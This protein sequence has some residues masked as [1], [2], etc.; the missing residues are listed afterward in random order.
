MAEDSVILRIAGAAG[1]VKAA[2]AGVELRKGD[3]GHLHR[4]WLDMQAAID[5][6]DALTVESGNV[7]TRAARAW[8]DLYFE[9]QMRGA[10]RRDARGP[11]QG[12]D[13]GGASHG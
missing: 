6:L 4:S 11:D 9:A 1:L 3:S 8:G 12:N 5:M 7:E 13:N 10:S 2:L